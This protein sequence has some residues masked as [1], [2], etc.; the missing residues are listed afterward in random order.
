MSEHDELRADIA[1]YALG[2]LEPGE[3]ARFEQHLA[4]CAACRAELAELGPVAAQLARPEVP[5]MPS[6]LRERTLAAVARSAAEAGAPGAAAEP[7]S[8]A[9]PASA[10]PRTGRLRRLLDRP[11][12]ARFAF[13]TAALAAL[14]A[15]LAVGYELDQADE[16]PKP[17]GPLE[18]VAT[19][20]ARGGAEASLDVFFTGIGRVIDFET[21]DLPILP[22]SDYYEL[23]FV[24]P[25]DR[26]GDPDR[27]S[28]GTFHP[29]EQGRS[30]STFT[31][32]VDPKKYPRIAVTL[33][34]GDGDPSPSRPDVM[35][36][37]VRPRS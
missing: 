9:R 20:E 37:R 34:R 6:D 17:P 15:A 21:N 27:I 4:G 29:D 36:G 1:G 3:R 24:G 19:L 26:P 8:A 31:A 13:A 18:A 2:A 11:H 30:R 28:A 7:E 33:E 5:A 10:R 25:D 12:G 14:L 16:R 23:W 22:K 35:R 32:A